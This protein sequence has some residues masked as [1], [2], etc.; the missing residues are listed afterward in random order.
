MG[1]TGAGKKKHC[2]GP[3]KERVERGEGA[4]G[5]STRRGRRENSSDFKRGGQ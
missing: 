4:V 3:K 5:P 1:S 2:G